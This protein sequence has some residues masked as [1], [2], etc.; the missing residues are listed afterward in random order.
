MIRTTISPALSVC[1]LLFASAPANADRAADPS[2]CTDQAILK[3]ISGKFA[4]A[5]RN[6]WHRGLL[7]DDIRSPRLRYRVLNGPTTIRHDHCQAQA[8][9]NDGSVRRIYYTVERRQGLASVGDNVQYCIVGL[10]PWRV[11]GAA[12]ST[13]R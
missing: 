4:W 9:M 12:C 1:A 3:R 13:V 11:Y 7:I 10:D 8:R 2:R 5:E 6:T